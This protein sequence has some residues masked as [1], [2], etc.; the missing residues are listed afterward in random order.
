MAAAGA[1][2]G[3]GYRWYILAEQA[4]PRRK[5]KLGGAFY[6]ALKGWDAARL[7]ACLKKVAKTKNKDL[8]VRPVSKGIQQLEMAGDYPD[9]VVASTGVEA[10]TAAKEILGKLGLD[11]A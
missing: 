5:K 9:V 6:F 7:G 4:P 8:T 2:V 10:M 11:K 1:P 3:T